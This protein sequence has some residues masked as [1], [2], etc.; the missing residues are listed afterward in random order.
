[1]DLGYD[2][3]DFNYYMSWQRDDGLNIDN[4]NYEDIVECIQ[5]YYQYYQS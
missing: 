3:A 2:E 5:G 1:M 4:W